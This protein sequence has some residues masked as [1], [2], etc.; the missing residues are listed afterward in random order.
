MIYEGYDKWDKLDAEE[1][2]EVIDPATPIAVDA[3]VKIDGVQGESL[4]DK[5]KNE[6]EIQGFRL[7]VR[8]LGST[9]TGGGS[10]SSKCFFHDLSVVKTVDKSTPK[11]WEKCATGEH[12]PKLELVIRKA[13]KDQLEY[14][15]ITLSDV[16]VSEHRHLTD[17]DPK[18]GLLRDAASFNFGKFEMEYKPQSSKGT[19]EGVVKA[20]YNIKEN[21]V[22]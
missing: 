2:E 4:D 15:K 22:V 21:K 3:F 14:I 17:P 19:G 1:L 20:G 16:L 18:S 8:Q 13:G 11:L 12:F 10:G 9:H 5:H 6:I 7:R